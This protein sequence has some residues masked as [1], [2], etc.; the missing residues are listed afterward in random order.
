MGIV[1]SVITELL[2]QLDVRDD[3]DL[4]LVIKRW[5]GRLGSGRKEQNL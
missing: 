2:R 1:I 5:T 3:N 4:D